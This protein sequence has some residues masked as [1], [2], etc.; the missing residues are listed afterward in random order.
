MGRRRGWGP[1]IN[2]RVVHHHHSGPGGFL[3]GI[4]G[5]VIG[6]AIVNSMDK[7]D[8]VVV[9]KKVEEKKSDLQS[10]LGRVTSVPTGAKVYLSLDEFRVLSDNNLIVYKDSVPYCMDRI[11]E[12]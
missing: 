3:G 6:G 12:V 2:R 1:P 11:V 9:E 7:P 10:V 4:V 5:G 8:V